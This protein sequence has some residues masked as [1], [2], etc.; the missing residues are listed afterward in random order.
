MAAQ[1][2]V[3]GSGGLCCVLLLQGPPVGPHTV[4]DSGDGTRRL[5]SAGIAISTVETAEKTWEQ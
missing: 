5:R 4:S 2:L 1:V 3:G